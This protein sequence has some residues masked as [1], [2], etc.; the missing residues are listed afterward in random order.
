MLLLII[1]AVTLSLDA[2]T[3]AFAYGLRKIRI[4]LPGLF[5]IGL[6]STVY[7]GVS[8]YFGV[9]L[10]QWIP[11]FAAELCGIFLLAAILVALLIQTLF[12][13]KETAQPIRFDLKPLGITIQ[14]IKNPMLCDFDRSHV[15]SAKEAVYLSL[16][17]SVDSLGVGLGFS[18]SS[19]AHPA[20]PLIVG[21]VQFFLC[22]LGNRI[23]GKI[24]AKNQPIGSRLQLI[25]CA[26]LGVLLLIRII[27]L[28]T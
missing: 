23:G 7:F 26:V 24:S 19:G 10:C 18:L 22:M 3:A 9:V 13:R 6:F 20:A 14:I 8:M 17:L 12:Q 28:F 21:T 2:F 11:P 5:V 16:A 15:I 4:G 25:S 27:G 1:L